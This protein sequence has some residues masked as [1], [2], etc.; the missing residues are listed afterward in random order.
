MNFYDSIA[1][2]YDLLCK[3]EQ[4][5]KLSIIRNNISIENN[6]ELLDVGCGTGISSDFNCFVVGADSSIKL[7]KQ[8]RNLRKV[9]CRASSFQR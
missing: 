6:T 8:N 1:K 3:E 2:E 5:K 9:L 4:L 7:L